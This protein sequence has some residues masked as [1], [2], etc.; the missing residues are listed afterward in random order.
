MVRRGESVLIILYDS[1]RLVGVLPQA[2]FFSESA[3]TE[4][5]YGT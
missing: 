4:V 2:L 3:V 5:R 1:V